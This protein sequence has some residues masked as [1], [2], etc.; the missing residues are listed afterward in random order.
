MSNI[1][2]SKADFSTFNKYNLWE[3]SLK[4]WR[5]NE[6]PQVNPKTVYLN[7]LITIKNFLLSKRIVLQMCPLQKLCLY[8]NNINYINLL[9]NEVLHSYNK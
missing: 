3:F 6:N 2:I 7:L 9:I 1:Y 8:N 5:N 4:I